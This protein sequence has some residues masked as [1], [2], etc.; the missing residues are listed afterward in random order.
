MTHQCSLA[1]P[2]Y[3]VPDAAVFCIPNSVRSVLH[4][5][6][7]SEKH[8]RA[9]YPTDGRQLESSAGDLQGETGGIGG[10]R[11]LRRTQ[12]YALA[13]KCGNRAGAY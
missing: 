4:S 3:L 1:V 10:G 7:G 11:K 8:V 13:S 9:G 12:R 6:C 5:F 2:D